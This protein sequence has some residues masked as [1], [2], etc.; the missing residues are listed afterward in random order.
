LWIVEAQEYNANNNIFFLTLYSIS[1]N[2]RVFNDILK[3]QNESRSK[4]KN[5]IPYSK[6][7]YASNPSMLGKWK[8]VLPSESEEV[9]ITVEPLEK[10]CITKEMMTDVRH[11]KKYLPKSFFP[12][13]DTYLYDEIE[14][15]LDVTLYEANMNKDRG[16]TKRRSK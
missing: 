5:F 8:I 9:Q 1:G 7:F 2:N 13:K 3:V 4:K 6:D 16:T 10:I 11:I 12:T 15:L 14:H